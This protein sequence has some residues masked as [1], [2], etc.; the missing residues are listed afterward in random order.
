[1]DEK[2]LAKQLR[3]ITIITIIGSLLLSAIGF[4]I[5]GY[6][7]KSAHEAEHAQLQ[8]ETA[9]YKER[10]LRQMDKNLQILTTLSKAYEVSTITDDP[11]QLGQSLM[12]TNAANDFVSMV[13]MRKDGTG[14]M[15]T[16]ESG[17]VEAITMDDLHPYAVEVMESAH[18]GKNTI[19]E[20]RHWMR[21][22]L[23]MLFPCLK[24]GRSLGHW[25]PEIPSIFS[26]MP[27]TAKRSWAG[28]A[29]CTSLP[30]TVCFWFGR[31][32]HWWTRK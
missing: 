13:Y 8:A 7:M 19:S 24:T 29:I 10:L 18:Q 32:I 15:H 1:M 27:P 14:L 31:K 2:K 12:E 21:R 16:T 28:Q 23:Y 20:V 30:I 26:Q 17:E 3:R 11:R 6:I 4:G 9:E 22:Y 25:Q 5:F